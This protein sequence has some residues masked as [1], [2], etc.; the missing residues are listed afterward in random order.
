MSKRKDYTLPVFFGGLFGIIA[1]MIW[2]F[3]MAQR[4]YYTDDHV[5]STTA[6][7]FLFIPIYALPAGL[8]GGLFL[9]TIYTP[10]RMIA[11]RGEARAT[12]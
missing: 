7:S 8:V 1:F 9:A 6:I 3:W 2:G 12:S 5:S 4:A 10:F 11:K